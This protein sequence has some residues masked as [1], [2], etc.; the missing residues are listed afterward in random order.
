MSVKLDTVIVRFDLSKT[1][2]LN[3]LIDTEAEISIISG[4]S[5]RRGFNYEPTQ[6]INVTGLSNALL[7]T[8]GT[9]I[10]KLFTPTH[11]TT[12]LFHIIGDSFDCRYGG[13]L[14]Q[15]FW[16]GKRVTLDYC[17]RTIIMGEVTMNFDNNTDRITG[18]THKLNVKSITE[19]IVQLHNKSK[20]LGIITKKEII[21]WVYLAETLTKEVDGYCVTSIVNKL[22]EDIT[23]DCPF[24]ELEETENDCDDA[25]LIFSNSVVENGNKLSKL[26]KEL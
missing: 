26:C 25:V 1:E 18:K 11:E 19:C 12:H 6:G 16:K 17:S 14:G 24:V 5:W 8:E 3:F 21:L 15:D 23:I 13:I 10:L 4:T 7:K 22:G 20:K 2:K 9:I